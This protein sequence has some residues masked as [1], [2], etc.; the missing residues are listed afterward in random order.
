MTDKEPCVVIGMGQLGSL[1]AVGFLRL[2]HPV[3]PLLRS[4]DPASLAER[5]QPRL[6]LA[7]VGEKD[8][9]GVL[10]TLP[11]AWRDRVVLLSNELLPHIWQA[12]QLQDPTVISVQFEK[13][14]AKPPGID[15]PSPVYGPLAETIKQALETWGIPTRRLM[16]QESMTRELVVK[17]LYILT[18]N[19]AGLATGGSAAEL[20]DQYRGLLDEVWEEL[21]AVQQAMV[22]FP[23]NRKELKHATLDYLSVAP[24]R[25]AGRSA[26]E[27]LERTLKHAHAHAVPVPTLEKIR[28]EIET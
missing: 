13:K 2:G 15:R 19:L 4:D 28:M 21:F 12:Y 9:P 26:A 16:D 8:L 24:A 14:D 10:K 5:L 3:Y 18:L 23:L 17:N 11:S 25:G 6:V 7:A 27:R 20:L 1:F 22:D